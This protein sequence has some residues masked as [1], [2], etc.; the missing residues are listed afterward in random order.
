MMDYLVIR[1]S[2]VLSAILDSLEDEERW[3]A[4]VSKENLVTKA[5]QV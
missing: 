3:E 5:Y 1:A 4:L 2:K